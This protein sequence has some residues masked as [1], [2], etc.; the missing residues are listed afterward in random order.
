MPPAAVAVK[1]RGADKSIDFIEHLEINM[2]FTCSVAVLLEKNMCSAMF[3]TGKPHW[4]LLCFTA[5]L[6]GE[7]GSFC[8]SL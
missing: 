5:I 6:V 8:F 1:H 7:K 3:T 4:V 2:G